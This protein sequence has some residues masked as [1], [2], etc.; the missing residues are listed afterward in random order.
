MLSRTL[1]RSTIFIITIL[2]IYLAFPI[3]IVPS[4]LPAIK[5]MFVEDEYPEEFFDSQVASLPTTDSLDPDVQIFELNI[6]TIPTA[7]EKLQLLKTLHQQGI[8]KILNPLSQTPPNS[9]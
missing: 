4:S 2:L 5:V 8:D 1:W 7:K 9:D 6:P 3:I